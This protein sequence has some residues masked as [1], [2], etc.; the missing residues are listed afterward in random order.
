MDMTQYPDNLLHT[1][2]EYKAWALT[3]RPFIISVNGISGT[4]KTRLSEA[5]QK[6]LSNSKI[7]YF[8]PANDHIESGIDDFTQW[9]EDGACADFY[10]LSLLAEDIETLK[11]AN[12]DFII[13]DFPFGRGH[14][15]IAPYINFSIFVDTPLD[16]ALARRIMWD[17]A[18]DNFHEQFHDMEHYLEKGRA[19]YLAAQEAG[20][21]DADLIVNGNSTIEGII[22]LI[23]ENIN[24]QG[25]QP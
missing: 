20:R 6:H 15:I 4:G 1:K 13:L 21:T 17:Y 18:P 8:E 7:L 12:L 14:K 16:I 11:Q 10:D 5:L 19:N 3:K 23:L 22:Q 9:T 24:R 2:T 25:G